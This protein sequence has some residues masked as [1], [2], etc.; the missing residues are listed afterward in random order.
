MNAGGVVARPT[1]S[2]GNA[3][4][5][6]GQAL[7]LSIGGGLYRA[8]AI[9]L[10]L[11]AWVFGVWFQP[12]PVSDW[13]YYWQASQDLSLYQ[14][15][16]A[17]LLMMAAFAATGLAPWIVAV[18]INLTAACALLWLVR[19]SAGHALQPHAIALY[20]L[21]IAPF[22]GVF[23]LDLL[24]AVGLAW[25]VW[26]LATASNGRLCRIA[27][28]T[29]LVAAAVS[30]R[31]Q[32]MLLLL[33][34]VGLLWI[35]PERRRAVRAPAVVALLGAMVLGFAADFAARAVAGHAEAVR[36]SS[37]VTLYAGLLVA[38]PDEHCGHWTER[39]RDAALEDID[40]PLLQAA[41][42]R[43]A[44][45][46]WQH[47]RA[48]LVCKLPQIV[49]PGPFALDWAA[50]AG[51][52]PVGAL[53]QALPTGWRRFEAW[54]YLALTLAIY[55]VTLLPRTRQALASRQWRWPFAWLLA[56]VA[57]HGVFEIQGRYFLPLLLLMPVWQMLGQRLDRNPIRRSAK[58][59]SDR[60][61]APV[62]ASSFSTQGV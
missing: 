39:A 8:E 13:L 11:L 56:F 33:A 28:G 43:L 47:W 55:L 61:P 54:A 17:G 50:G 44:H 5:E 27:A 20:L 6:T 22:F 12:Q 53:G 48:V 36:T 49:V 34:W 30:T 52:A 25:G 1:S 38:E 42:Q 19:A 60:V 23:Q 37:A 3:R 59:A 32:L 40:Q 15:G 26:L 7:T 45:R 31:P 14:R 62:P 16:G 35:L 18:T 57:V 41:W 24:A 58:L 2:S 21:L 51:A 4:S 10:I 46:D 9:A 29:L